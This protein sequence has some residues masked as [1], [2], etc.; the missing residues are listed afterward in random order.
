MIVTR[1]TRSIQN[2]FIRS[3][4]YSKLIGKFLPTNLICL[5]GG[6]YIGGNLSPTL[7]LCFKQVYIINQSVFCFIFTCFKQ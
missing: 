7:T 1:L 4:N 2:F 5:F 3:R 6:F